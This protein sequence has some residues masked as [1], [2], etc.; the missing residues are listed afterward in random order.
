MADAAAKEPS[1]EDILASIRKIIAQDDPRPR[2]AD[3]A[4]QAP[5]GNAPAPAAVVT[6]ERPQAPAAQHSASTMGQPSYRTQTAPRPASATTLAA[7]ANQV[8]KEMPRSAPASAPV[9]ASQGLA[10]ATARQ[11]P[12]AMPAA[13]P[14]RPAPAPARAPAPVA[15]PASNAEVAAFRDALVSPSAGK[16]VADSIDR[17]KSA[18]ADDTA[19]RIEAVLRP[20]L[21]E[22]LDQ[23]LPQM[24]ERI[25]RQEIERL[26]NR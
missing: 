2:Q 10:A 22:W 12:A 19:A 16:A 24:V 3:P 11:Q 20:M 15:P 5:S 6:A 23:N 4:A 7:L 13:A 17:L 9:P 18:L 26:V 8:R 14:A 25:V 1:M 21:R